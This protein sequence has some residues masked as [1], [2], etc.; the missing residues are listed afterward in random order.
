MQLSYSP[1]Y[2][3]SEPK[4]SL[5]THQLVMVNFIMEANGCRV[6]TKIDGVEMLLE[7]AVVKELQFTVFDTD[8]L[9]CG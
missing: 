9:P 2:T 3:G 1:K 5:S 6:A 4:D 7:N 8:A